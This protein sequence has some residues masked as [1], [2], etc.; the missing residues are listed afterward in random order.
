M[1]GLARWAPRSLLPDLLPGEDRSFGSGLF[2][3]LVPQSCW[4]TNVR[5]CVAAADWDRVR[6][7]V[8]RRAGDRCGCEAC[9][10]DRDPETGVRM[11]ARER[12]YFDDARGVQVLRRLICLCSGCRREKAG[13]NPA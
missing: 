4:F 6:Q 2:V 3:D 11:E 7:M 5:T 12:W 1:A 9:G 8:F 13:R 10:R